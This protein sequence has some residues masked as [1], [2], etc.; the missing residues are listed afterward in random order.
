[1]QA[2]SFL[3][4]RLLLYLLEQRIGNLAVAWNLSEMNTICPVLMVGTTRRFQSGGSENVSNLLALDYS[5]L[6]S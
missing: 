5:L 1:M 6:H 4:S 2:S 3:D